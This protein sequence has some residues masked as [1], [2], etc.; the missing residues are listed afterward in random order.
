MHVVEL[1]QFLPGSVPLMCH[2]LVLSSYA[3][4]CDKL[5]STHC[6]G[7]FIPF[8]KKTTAQRVFGCNIN[9]FCI[10]GGSS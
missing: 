6:F 7:C 9:A 2:I 1:G 10:L 8:P 5:G 4:C 3:A